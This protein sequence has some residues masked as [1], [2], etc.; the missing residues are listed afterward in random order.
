MFAIQ[1]F[2]AQGKQRCHQAAKF[3]ATGPCLP[4]PR[5]A[6]R[7]LIPATK[8]GA[9]A[10]LDLIVTW[11]TSIAHR[12]ERPAGLGGA[13]CNKVPDWRRRGEPVV[14]YDAIVPSKGVRRLRGVFERVA[15][16]LRCLRTNGAG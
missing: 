1:G 11:D 14:P 9:M 5:K 6:M 7:L 12:R 13:S 8:T 16:A 3:P 15:Q 2:I 10:N 4:A